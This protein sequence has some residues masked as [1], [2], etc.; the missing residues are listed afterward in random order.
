MLKISI[1]SCVIIYYIVE[2]KRF[3]HYCL[4]VVIVFIRE[5]FLRSHIKDYFKIN[6][7]QTIKMS[8]KGENVKYSKKNKIIIHDLCGF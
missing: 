7:K 1:D 3:C 6:G 4:H 8:K 2:K 5:E